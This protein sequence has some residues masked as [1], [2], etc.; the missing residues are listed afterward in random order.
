M[1]FEDVAGTEVNQLPSHDHTKVR[2]AI[3]SKA[4]QKPQALSNKST[5]TA[6]S[7]EP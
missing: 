7:V 3:T 5:G 6:A 4:F 2:C 1:H